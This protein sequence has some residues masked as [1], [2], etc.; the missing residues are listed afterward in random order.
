MY[1]TGMWKDYFF[2]TNGDIQSTVFCCVTML[3]Y[4]MI[5]TF[6]FYI[7]CR[8]SGEKRAQK[9]KE[10]EILFEKLKKKGICGYYQVMFIML[11]SITA[12][13]LVY[14]ID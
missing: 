14:L 13:V 11:R 4:F 8:Y 12:W 10:Y 3:A 2:T 5:V 9:M 1:P 6:T 7:M